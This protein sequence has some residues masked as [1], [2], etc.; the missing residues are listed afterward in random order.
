MGRGQLFV[1]SLQAA[2]CV[3][4]LE[5]LLSELERLRL[6]VRIRA[7][8]QLQV[9]DLRL[10]RLH[11]RFKALDLVAD[12]LERRRNLLC[13]TCGNLYSGAVTLSRVELIA[14]LFAEARSQALNLG[15]LRL[16]LQRHFLARL[17]P[18]SLR[19]ANCL[20]RD[21]FIYVGEAFP[22]RLGPASFKNVDNELAVV[23]VRLKRRNIRAPL[24][25]LMSSAQRFHFSLERRD[26]TNEGLVPSGMYCLERRNIHVWWR[27][28][29]QRGHTYWI[30]RGTLE[31]LCLSFGQ[32]T[33]YTFRLPLTNDFE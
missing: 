11:R 26:V 24:V 3:A 29:R 2:Q 31:K 25:F 9:A 23:E 14:V 17:W 33:R 19:P 21:K 1:G 27:R 15:G 13:D 18:E 5:V 32:S 7:D 30:V 10:P 4:R 28:W 6:H 22:S 8:L 12:G 20:A 16:E